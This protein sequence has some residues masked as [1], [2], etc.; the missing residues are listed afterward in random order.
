[1]STSV[2]E[3][4]GH[5]SVNG[6]TLSRPKVLFLV[7]AFPPEEETGTTLLAEGYVRELSQRGWEVAVL[8][9]SPTA[10]SWE[11]AGAL[12]HPGESFDRIPVPGPPLFMRGDVWSLC[13]PSSFAGP[14]HPLNVAF[15]RILT[16]V[17]PD[18]VHVVDNVNLSLDW[19]ERAA[20]RGI[21]VVRTVSCAEDLCGLIPPVSP[22]SDAVGYCLPP[23]TP[24]R[25]ARCLA[26][27]GGAFARFEIGL[28]ELNGDAVSGPGLSHAEGGPARDSLIDLLERKRAR[29]ATQY[30]E[31]FSRVI[32]SSRGFRAYFEGTT[33][34]P[35]ER[36]VVIPLGID[37]LPGQTRSDAS[38][39][40][41]RST[42]PLRADRPLV[43]GS[44][45]TVAAHKGSDALVGAFLSPA[46]LDR[47]DYRLTII[48][49]GDTSLLTELLARN[50]NVTWH[51]A[52]R[53]DELPAL[54]GGID[55]GLSTSRFETFHRVTREYL[56]SGI[57]VIGSMAFGIP[58]VVHPGRNG[59]LFDHAEPGSLQRAVTACLD[60][61]DL[62]SR[63][64]AGARTTTIKSVRDEID[65]MVALYRE[66]LDHAQA[67][68]PS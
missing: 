6:R 46:L 68:R 19:P 63:L 15:E 1:V 59:L 67:G 26:S 18:L 7:H 33:P 54:L 47:D 56:L 22:I 10:R 55:I 9:V 12:R 52:Y 62:V 17:A 20:A 38:A 8:Y 57:P 24:E 4:N 16:E 51:G 5:G 28:S 64:T 31:T 53:P 30:G 40:S 3:T 43:F 25:C 11:T 27:T 23:L 42:D 65:Q 41:D 39:D 50:P 37:P 35:P 34:L 29:T 13:A 2:V 21:P 49:G 48:G 44:V 66:C 58:E 60:D 36:A 14:Q 45:G 32:F 61:A